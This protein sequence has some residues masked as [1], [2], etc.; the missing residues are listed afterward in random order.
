MER[1]EAYRITYSM[2]C[3][4][5]IVVPFISCCV[6]LL[7]TIKGG[8]P[9]PFLRKRSLCGWGY[10]VSFASALLLHAIARYYSDGMPPEWKVLLSIASLV[11]APLSFIFIML[12]TE[13]IRA[14][15]VDR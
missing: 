3:M 11:F 8:R 15:L 1:C 7:M 13:A 9:M 14:K 10:S 2:L 5:C 6:W 12:F 4:L